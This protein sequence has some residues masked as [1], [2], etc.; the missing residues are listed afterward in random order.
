VYTRSMNFIVRSL[1][2]PEVPEMWRGDFTLATVGAP[3]GTASG[4]SDRR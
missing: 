1:A 2:C 4:Q 3:I